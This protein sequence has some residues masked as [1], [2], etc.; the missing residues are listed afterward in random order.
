[1]F[2]KVLTLEVV[3]KS[4]QIARPAELAKIRAVLY[5]ALRLRPTPNHLG[6]VEF[7]LLACCEN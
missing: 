2:Q 6:L 5:P 7:H 3:E 4:P 1:M